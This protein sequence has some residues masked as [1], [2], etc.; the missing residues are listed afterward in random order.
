M[1]TPER[2]S[3]ELRARLGELRRDF[4]ELPAYDQR[5]ADV[6]RKTSGMIAEVRELDAQMTAA[7]ILERRNPF[8][9]AMS[10]GPIGGGDMPTEL[11]SLGRQLA[12]SDQF[13]AYIAGG[14]QGVPEIRADI[15]GGIEALE[16]RDIQEWGSTG[17]TSYFANG[18]YDSSNA[19]ML[20]P[21]GQPIAPIPRQA[22]LYLRDLIPKMNTSLAQIP[23]V[24]ELAPTANELAASAV[25]EGTIK[26]NAGIDFAG[27]MAAVTVIAATMT[28]S[29][30]LFEDS[31]AIVQYVNQ[32]L[33]YLV[34]FKE[35][36]EFLNGSGTWPDLQGI[37]NTPGVQTQAAVG[38]NDPAVTLGIAFAD[39]ENADGSPT[40]VVMNPQDAW[41][42]FTRRTSGS[43]QLDGI[44]FGA[45]FGA[46]PMTVWGVPT[47]RTRAKAAGSA[48][49]ADFTRGA[50]II[51][52]QQVNVQV[53]QERYAELN[54]VLLICEER[55]GLAVFRPDLFVNTT[56]VT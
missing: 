10:S 37:L 29:K 19:G 27:A 18:D 54:E 15:R 36:A 43:G 25:S 11:R 47:Y 42:M 2:T 49:V 51:D 12:E 22:K 30:Q 3:D 45:P 21:V 44:T 7:L 39:V 56:I 50:M 23:Y 20:V 34:K 53:Y 5:D 13:K 17:P 14:C 52:R 40:A 24:R 32:R 31:A 28:F 41:F 9:P 6:N 38:T 55:L 26:P 1:N 33:P 4:S 16:R 48:L 46:L 35:D 8:T